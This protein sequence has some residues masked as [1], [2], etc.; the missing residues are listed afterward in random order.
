MGF[1]A[2]A[3]VFGALFV[4]AC[5]LA[6][7]T[8][9]LDRHAR[10]RRRASHAPLKRI[11]D[12]QRDEVVRVRGIV[13]ALDATIPIP[14]SQGAGVFHV[15]LLTDAASPTQTTTFRRAA[16]CEFIIDDGTGQARIAQD[17]PLE[18]VG[19][20][21]TSGGAG[22]DDPEVAA[23]LDGDL[24][25]LF[26]KGASVLWEQQ[27]ISVGEEIVVWGRCTHE[28]VRGPDS[29]RGYRETPL[30]VVLVPVEADLPL[31]VKPVT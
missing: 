8:P 12:V 4:S 13:R 2:I 25:V 19:R 1:G 20:D 17:V 16:R 18:I 11:C 21:P 15:T 5:G 10:L 23:F 22:R 14:Y 29:A 28:P 9:L 3:I 31:V 26:S 6:T 24:D 30:R 27:A 7:L